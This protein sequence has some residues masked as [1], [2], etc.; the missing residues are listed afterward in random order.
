MTRTTGPDCAITCNLINTHTHI[1]TSVVDAMG[2]TGVT[3][4]ERKRNVDKKMLVQ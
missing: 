3:W 1:D 2:E 4:V